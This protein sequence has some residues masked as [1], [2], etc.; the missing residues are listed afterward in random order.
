VVVPVEERRRELLGLAKRLRAGELISAED[1]ELLA[2]LLEWKVAKDYPEWPAELPPGIKEIERCWAFLRD[3]TEELLYSQFIPANPSPGVVYDDAG[4]PEIYTTDI[5]R[6]RRAMERTLTA[7]RDGASK[8][9]KRGRET[10]RDNAAREREALRA[11]VTRYREQHPDQGRPAVAAALLAE[12]G[13]TVDH[14]DPAD[15]ERAIRALTKKI[16]RLEKSLDT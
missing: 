16:E 14:A 13:R 15:R 11:A 1:R 3:G 2:R 8:G 6:E 4:L 9:G 10:R 5:Q 12:H 7:V